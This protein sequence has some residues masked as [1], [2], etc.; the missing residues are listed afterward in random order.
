MPRPR[1]PWLS[2]PVLGATLLTIV[3]VAIGGWLGMWQLDAWKAD[4]QQSGTDRTSEK[5]IPLAEAMGP[6]QPFP[7]NAVGRPVI[8]S[9]TWIPDSTVLIQERSRGSERG[10]WVAS[11]VASD[12][13]SGSALYVVRQFV[14]D[15]GLADPEPT[16]AMNGIV[17]LDAAEGSNGTFD[18]DPDDNVLPRMRTADLVQHVDTDLY[19]GFG[20]LDPV[21]LSD[22][23]GASFWTGLRNFFYAFEWWVFAAFVIF[24]WARFMQELRA[25][26]EAE[27]EES[28]GLV[29][30]R[31]LGTEPEPDAGV[32]LDQ[33]GP[34]DTALGVVTLSTTTPPPDERF[35][36]IADRPGR[37][38]AVHSVLNRYRV[39]AYIVGVLLIVL[40]LIGLPLKYFTG[41]GMWGILDSTP[42][43]VNEGSTANQVG[44][45]ITQYLG[46]AHGWL[47]MIFLFAAFH[48]ALRAR[49]P[50]GFSVVTLLCGTIPVASF[51]AEHRTA[52]RVRA[53]FP[54]EFEAVP[55]R[56]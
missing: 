29:A 7:G 47:Y 4:R 42:H 28:F 34:A 10:Y 52:K 51:W 39:M 24:M 2:V 48:L 8:L 53:E 45:W 14:T 46:V 43:L 56:T 26:R 35:E 1:S 16:G 21:D 22:Q 11:A 23:P 17:W 36:A 49:L 40:I 18:D 13:G 31:D 30:T 19:S 27:L 44:D 33:A 54:E 50:L 41:E 6:D 9:G 20:V 25:D 37:F 3:L 38:N 55:S 15:P 5:P 32:P 12:N